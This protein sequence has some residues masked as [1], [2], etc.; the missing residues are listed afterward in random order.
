[1][2]PDAPTSPSLTFDWP[3]RTGFPFLFLSCV[4]VSLLAHAATFVL[5]QASDPP[6]TSIPRTAPTISVLTPSSPEAIALL[7]WIDA[8]DPALVATANSITPPGIYDIAYTSSYAT[9]RTAPLGPPEA[10]AAV[11]FPPAREPL[12]VIASADPKRVFPAVAEDPRPTTFLFSGPLAARVPSPFPAFG[13]KKR[14]TAPVEASR[15]LIGVTERGEVRFLFPQGSSGNPALDD[16]AAAY[17]QKLAFAPSD[18]PIVWATATVTWGDDAYEIG[19]TSIQG[20][21]AP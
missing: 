16:Q 11:G 2:K 5:F 20:P 13:W 19:K 7:H 3:R 17:V 18:Q 4:A 12:A 1:M 15:F 10:G 21:P 14:A 6:G 9:M 8:Q